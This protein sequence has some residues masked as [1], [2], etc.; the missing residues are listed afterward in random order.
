LEIVAEPGVE[1]DLKHQ[2]KDKR[3]VGLKLISD[4]SHAQS[5]SAV[6]RL[7]G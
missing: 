5:E 1:Q 4:D 7:A 6:I 3:Q 2:E